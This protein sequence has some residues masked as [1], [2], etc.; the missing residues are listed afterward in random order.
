MNSEERDGRSRIFE[1][2]LPVTV[3][4]FYDAVLGKVEGFKESDGSITF[5]IRVP[6]DS[7]SEFLEV[8]SNLEI[9]QFCFAAKPTFPLPKK[10]EDQ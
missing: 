7:A 6:P 3:G 10:K 5:D 2:Q 1:G 8:I 9:L 4:F